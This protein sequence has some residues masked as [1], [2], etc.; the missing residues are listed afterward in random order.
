MRTLLFILQKEFLQIFRNRAMLPIIFVMPIIQLIILG[1]AAT[2]EI[3]EIEV[4]VVDQDNTP[5][6]RLLVR[7]LEASGYFVRVGAPP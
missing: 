4:V 3:R 2:F 5:T 1:N 7:K 6:S